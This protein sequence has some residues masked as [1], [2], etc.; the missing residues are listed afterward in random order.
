M[1][2]KKR[3]I[4]SDFGLYTVVDFDGEQLEATDDVEFATDYAKNEVMDED[5]SNVIA[6]YKLYAVYKRPTNVTPIKI[7]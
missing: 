4:P 3:K 2:T 1:S 6:V 7:Y 5:S